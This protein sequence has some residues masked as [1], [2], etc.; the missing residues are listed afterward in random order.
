MPFTNA[1]PS[2]PWSGKTPTSRHCSHAAAV[3]AGETRV[4]KAERYRQYLQGVGRATDRQASIDLGWEISSIT[5]IRNGLV[6]RG[7]VEVA[8]TIMGAHSKRVTL[9]RLVLVTA[10]MCEGKKS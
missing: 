2:L 8:G 10:A 3:S 5:S 1:Q 6:D 4:W 9:W 7:M